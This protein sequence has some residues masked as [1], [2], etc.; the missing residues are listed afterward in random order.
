M[1]FLVIPAL[2][3]T[4]ARQSVLDIASHC[5]YDTYNTYEG[6]QRAAHSAR[7]KTKTLKKLPIIRILLSKMRYEA[8]QQIEDCK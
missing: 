2:T 4:T 3:G 7:F 1:P 6:S 5:I 8:L